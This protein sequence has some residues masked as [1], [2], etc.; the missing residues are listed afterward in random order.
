MEGA[1]AKLLLKKETQC[2]T[3]LW[4]RI[5]SDLKLFAGSESVIIH[6]GSGSDKLQFLVNKIA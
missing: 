3:V 1:L 2:R 6:F 4:I 5:Q